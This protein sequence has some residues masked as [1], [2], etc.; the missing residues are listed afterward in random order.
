MGRRK[1]V[2]IF[3]TNQKIALLVTGAM[4]LVSSVSIPV[5]ASGPFGEIYSLSQS[6]PPNAR[7]QQPRH[8]L[9]SQRNPRVFRDQ[10]SIHMGSPRPIRHHPEPKHTSELGTLNIYNECHI[11]Y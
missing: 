2:P 10:L 8:H 5:H 9:H 11:P 3:R 4:L 6:R 1:E 7:V